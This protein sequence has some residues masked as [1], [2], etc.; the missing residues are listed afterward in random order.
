MSH[1]KTLSPLTDEKLKAA[2]GKMSHP[3]DFRPFVPVEKAPPALNSSRRARTEEVMAT[4]LIRSTHDLWGS[5]MAAPFTGVTTDGTLRP[6]PRAAA[7][8]GAP[9]DRMEAAAKALLDILRPDIAAQVT[10]AADAPE[11]R[12]WHN[13]PVQWERDGIGLEEMNEDERRAMHALMKASLSPAGYDHLVELMEVNRF[14]GELV[15]RPAYLNENCYSVGIFGTPGDDVWG[16]QIYGHHLCLACR[17]VGDTYVLSPTFLAAEPTVVDEGAMAGLNA[18]IENEEAALA[19]IRGLAPEQR[20]KAITLDSILNADVPEGRRH[21]ADSLHLGGAFQDNRVIPLEGVCAREFRAEDRARLMALFETFFILLPEGP[22]QARLSE[23][24]GHLDDTW[25]CWMGGHDDWSPFYFRLQ[26][27]VVLAEF[28]HHQAVFL[29][30]S[31]PARFH[32]HT[33]TR[34]PEGG[35]YGND[36]LQKQ[37]GRE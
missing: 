21:W 13:M 2:Y 23:I 11:W 20:R 22:K 35:D 18:F 7:P 4:D 10:F 9:R 36:L 28:D 5:M 8:N 1:S 33:L 31:E 17:L 19:L 29:T 12:R 24:E 27:P 6:V 30:N 34:I 16:W 37:R 3:R 25:L 32:V 14:S 26:S 15:G